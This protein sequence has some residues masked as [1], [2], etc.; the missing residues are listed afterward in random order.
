MKFKV[1]FYVCAYNVQ[2]TISR[3]LNSIINQTIKPLEIIVVDDGSIDDTSKILLNFKTNV[4]I[5]KN[6][7]NL[8][9]AQSRN[10][11]INNLSGD[12][13][14]AIDADVICSKKW[15]KF[16]LKDLVF[17]N[18]DFENLMDDIFLH[19]SFIC[20]STIELF[21]D[22]CFTKPNCFF[23]TFKSNVFLLLVASKF[24]LTIV[25]VEGNASSKSLQRREVQIR[26]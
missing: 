22:V 18:I 17:K 14:A 23:E 24:N 26:L 25:F 6:P 16:L 5:I 11:A 10:I 21:E 1:S 3:C 7:K 13:V 2:R 12:Y 9:I 4:K 19:K 15:L 20:S 8:G